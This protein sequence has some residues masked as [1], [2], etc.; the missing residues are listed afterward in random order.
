MGR[1]GPILPPLKRIPLRNLDTGERG[2]GNG[3]AAAAVSHMS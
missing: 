1:P 3:A 2:G